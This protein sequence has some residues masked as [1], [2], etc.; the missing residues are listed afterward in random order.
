MKTLLSQAIETLPAPVP[1]WIRGTA[2]YVRY[3]R[4]RERRGTHRRILARLDSPGRVS[5]G[6]F[7]GMRYLALSYCSEIL[8]KLV[9]TYESELA[10]AIEAICRADCDRIVDIGTAE[11]YYAVGMAL[12]NPRAEM[13]GYEIN[14]SARYYLRRLA[15]L[16]GVAERF[17]IRGACSVDSLADSVVGAHRPAVICDCE[18][19]E[20]HLLDPERVEPL[21]R[22]WILVETHDGLET[23]EGVLEGITGRLHRRFAATHEIDVITSRAR[24][25][26]ELPL[27]CDSL[28]DPEAAEAMDEGRPW[29]QWLFLRPR[30][31]HTDRA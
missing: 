23:G 4:V 22:A 2:R 19:A 29:A 17:D 25:R 8:P 27:G 18:G 30:A 12:R 24:R 7:R 21:R 20:D 26:D 1:V 14:P 10:E 15:R 16:N 13:V 28:T 11:G 31:N 9:G 5:Q 3:R 6:P